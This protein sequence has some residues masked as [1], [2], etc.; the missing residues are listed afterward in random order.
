MVEELGVLMHEPSALLE[1][2]E[3]FVLPS[4]DARKDVMGAECLTKLVPQHLIV[5]GASGYVDGPPRTRISPQLLCGEEDFLSFHAAQEPELELNHVKLV[6]GFQRL[7]CL[8]EER[9]VS[10][11]EVSICGWSLSMVVPSPVAST[12]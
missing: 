9:R 11:H 2:Y 6:I 1:V 8:S 12:S 4:H 10:G 7:S 5:H 3:F